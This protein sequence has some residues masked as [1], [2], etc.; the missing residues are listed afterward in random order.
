MRKTPAT[1]QRKRLNASLRMLVEEL[2]P[3]LDSSGAVDRKDVRAEDLHEVGQ[4]S[5]KPEAPSAHSWTSSWPPVVIAFTVG[6]FVGIWIS[7]W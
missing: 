3:D 2:Q 4:A 5:A 1:D 7:T 6:I